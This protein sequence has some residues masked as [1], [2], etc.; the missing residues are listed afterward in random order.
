MER[1]LTSPT[2]PA[3]PMAAGASASRSPI[4]TTMAGPTSMCPTTARTA[5]TTTITTAR[6]PM[7]PK[8][9]VSRSAA[10]PPAQP[11]AITTATACSTSSFPATSTTISTIP[12]W[13]ARAAS[14][15]GRANTAASTFFAGPWAFSA[16]STI[17]FTT[18]ATAPSPTSASKL[19][20]PIAKSVTGF[21]DFANDSFLD[22]FIANGHVYHVAD[23]RDWATT[24]AQRPQLFRNLEGAK[25]QEVPPA[26]GSGLA[27]VVCARGAAFGGLFTDGQIAVVL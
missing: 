15:K 26:T 6:L 22:L 2:K 24:W 4:T 21:L 3:S 19:A 12:S 25:F 20:L 14:P 17:F 10:G 13:Q 27:S 23:Q 9:P 18:T 16:K 8:K 1:S 7:S 11:G 5:S